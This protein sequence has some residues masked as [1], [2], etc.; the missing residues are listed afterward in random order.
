[1][2]WSVTIADPATARQLADA[3]TR[4]LDD[5]RDT[6]G[7]VVT[8]SIFQ[9]QTRPFPIKV[10][11]D[12]Q[13]AIKAVQAHADGLD[14]IAEKA[15]ETMWHSGSKPYD[16]AKVAGEKLLSLAAAFKAS[17]AKSGVVDPAELA[18]GPIQRDG[19]VIPTPKNMAKF[20]T[21]FTPLELAVMGFIGY[22]VFFKKRGKR[23]KLAAAF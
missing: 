21:N 17:A 23:G 20:F 2:E 10:P 19:A 6:I 12:L 22:Q 7:T 15:P 5:A 1:M 14:I 3:M 13:A 16:T 8:A 9:G 11:A 4:V 18:R